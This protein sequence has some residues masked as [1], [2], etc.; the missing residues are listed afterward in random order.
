MEIA[1][2]CKQEFEV[3]CNA[4]SYSI[5]GVEQ[6]AQS[7]T[8]VDSIIGD[9]G[10][11]LLEGVKSEWERVKNLSS[12]APTAPEAEDEEGDDS[13]DPAFAGKTDAQ[14]KKIKKIRADKAA[15]AAKKAA[16]KKA[17]KGEGGAG[18]GVEEVFKLTLGMIFQD[19]DVLVGARSAVEYLVQAASNRRKPKVAKGMRDYLPAQ[20]A[21]RQQVFQAIRGVFSRHG[22]VEIDT[23]VMELKDT[24]T[25]KYGEVREG[26][27]GDRKQ[28]DAYRE[29]TDSTMP[30]HLS[31]ASLATPFILPFCCSPL[32][33]QD[34]KLI[35]DLKDQ[36]G[37]ILALRYDLTV[38]FA[39]FL[40]TNAVGNIKRYHIGKVYRRDQPQMAKGRYREF[41]QCDFD[42]AGK[43]GRMVPDAE[44]VG[45]AAEILGSVEIGDFRIKV[46]H[47]KL[48]D[49]ILEVAG[50][51]TDKFRTIC[52]AVDKLDKETWETVKGEMIEK[53]ISGEV[54]MFGMDGRSEV[55]AV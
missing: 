3:E 20:M 12:S 52:S 1:T 27:A 43:Y 29:P 13:N 2:R 36:G 31:L 14:I 8:T 33:P 35:Y 6:I 4:L 53:G 45:V 34:T 30:N 55:T 9:G 49:S 10:M 25:G 26:E 50:V 46:N 37:E 47:R 44:C 11:G 16:A 5:V 41:Y 40:A 38:P 32:P 22:A 19:S 21:I 7:L 42:V 24:L 39:R 54:S 48:L 28:D 17:K 15:K 51:G 18:G 23:P